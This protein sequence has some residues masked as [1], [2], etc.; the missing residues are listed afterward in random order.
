MYVYVNYLEKKLLYDPNPKEVE[1]KSDLK[2]EEQ[3]KIKGENPELLGVEGKKG[4]Q[5][6]EKKT[7]ETKEEGIK[8]D[9]KDEK[10]IENNEENKGEIKET[11]IPSE[12][13]ITTESE[14]KG[15]NKNLKE[16]EKEH[17]NIEKPK[18]EN[19]EEGF[20]YTAYKL[21]LQFL[22]EKMEL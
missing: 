7:G 15:E 4:D 13:G 1:I 3:K 2:N 8:N 10:K 19:K 5:N 22:N 9:I 18:S 6:E 16:K 20:K 14:N 12:T 17:N 21:I 11:K